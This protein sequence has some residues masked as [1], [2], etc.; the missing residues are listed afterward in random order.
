MQERKTFLHNNS[1]DVMLISE[2]H[3]TNRTHLKIPN[4]NIYNTQY[5]DGTAQ[6]GTAIIIKQNIKHYERM[7][8][9]QENIQATTVTIQE[10]TGELT[11]SAV[12]CPPKHKNKCEDFEK[13]FKTQGNNFIVAGDFNA[14][15]TVWGSRITTTK[16]IELLHAM[17]NNN[18]SYLS[19]GKPT[20]WPANTKKNTRCTRLLC[21]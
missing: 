5:P 17:G 11:I 13:F 18:L 2:E 8:Y 3:Y 1:I 20:S 12:Y 21:N 6:A 7:E 4:Y 9:K 14:K 15:H 19:T 10:H 16:E